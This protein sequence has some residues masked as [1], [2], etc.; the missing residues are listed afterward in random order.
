M[1][2]GDVLA[3]INT[4]DLLVVLFLFAMFLLG[5]I[6]G[7]IRRLLGIGSMLFSFLL[8]ANVKEPLGAFLGAN[9]TQFPPEYGAMVGFLT[10][11]VA[12]LVAFTLTIQ[13]TY[14]KTALFEQFTFV[15]ELIAGFLGVVQG[16]LLLV[17]LKIILDSYF[18]LAFPVD[19]QEIGFL[20]TGW[21]A[22]HESGTGDLLNSTIIP[23]LLAIGGLLVPESIKALYPPA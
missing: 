8:A 6:Q 2:I 23:R 16:M 14:R 15:D 7:T 11:F 18:L 1:N 20:R 19:P 21:Q 22:L 13:G 3:G 9:W 12:A 4:T 17:F 10:V 5:F